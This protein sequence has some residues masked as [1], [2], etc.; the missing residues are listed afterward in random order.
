MSLKSLRATGHQAGRPV[1]PGCQL[2]VVIAPPTVPCPHW[3]RG[4]RHPLIA[5][6]MV[7]LTWS[8]LHSIDGAS[9]RLTTRA[10]RTAEQYAKD[11]D[12]HD[13]EVRWNAVSAS[14]ETC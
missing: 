8:P 9:S 3:S 6:P 14:F 12:P 1:L 11:C 2:A 4:G 7:T 5:V 13:H 10:G